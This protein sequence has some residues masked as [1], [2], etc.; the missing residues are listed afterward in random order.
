MK[1]KFRVSLSIIAIL[2]LLFGG[3][4]FYFNRSISNEEVIEDVIKGYPYKLSKRA[5]NLYKKH[6]YE[7]KDIL[8][9]DSF[10]KEDY[11]KKISE[12]FIIDVYTLTNKDNKYD[13]GGSIFIYP[14]IRENYELNLKDTLYKYLNNDKKKDRVEVKSVD[15]VSIEEDIFLINEKE[16]NVYKVNIIWEYKTDKGYDNK[17]VIIIKE[18]DKLLHIIEF[19][20]EYERSN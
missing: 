11:A 18:E 15:I 2:I 5:T 16:E 9:G 8:E 7:L 3:L 19:K 20:G 12:L 4:Y 1:R 10:K 14:S 13:V 17:G 6:F